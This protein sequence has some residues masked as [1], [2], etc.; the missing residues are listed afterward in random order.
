MPSEF[1]EGP[2]W[3]Q[4]AR[5]EAELGLGPAGGLDWRACQA[6]VQPEQRWAMSV[7]KQRIYVFGRGESVGT[8][9]SRARLRG[10]TWYRRLLA[11]PVQQEV[12]ARHSTGHCGISGISLGSFTCWS[13][14]LVPSGQEGGQ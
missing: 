6:G 4:G 8:A 2:R 3:T 9:E 10:F 13:P 5:E 12:S 11:R 1:R 7:Q 14:R